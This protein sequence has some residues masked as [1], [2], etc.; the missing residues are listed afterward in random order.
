MGPTNDPTPKDEPPF[1][2]PGL[3]E[4]FL[5]ELTAVLLATS[6]IDTALSELATA[7][8][9]ITPGAPMAGVTLR[10]GGRVRTVAS[11]EATALLVDEIQYD[12]G[13]AGGPCLEAI[14]SGRVVQVDDLATESRWG[15]YSAYL[16]AH[17]LRSVYSHPL[18]AGEQVIGAL[19]MYAPATADSAFGPDARQAIARVAEH[20]GL[21]LHAVLQAARHAEITAQLRDALAQRATIEQAVGVL[22]GQRRCS[23]EE[24]FAIMRR[25]GQTTDRSLGEVAADVITSFTGQ[26]PRPSPFVDPL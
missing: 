6:G 26:R 15:E 24:A 14:D 21:L 16:L 7:A 17:G 2:D 9:R 12:N 25:A 8:S 4:G 13:P 22:M 18:R 5:Q 11:S 23:A 19:N 3:D 20:T 1:E 10:L